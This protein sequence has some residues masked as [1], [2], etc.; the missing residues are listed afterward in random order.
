MRLIDADK[1]NFKEA[2][3]G[4]S[5]LAREMRAA[6]QALIDRQPTAYDVE[7]VVAGLNNPYNY[8]IFNGKHITTKERAIEIVRDGGD[9]RKI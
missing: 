2:I 3:V 8:T 1:I 4:A 7:K 5:D 9:N 6:A